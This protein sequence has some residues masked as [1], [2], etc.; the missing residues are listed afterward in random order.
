MTRRVGAAVTPGPVGLAL[1]AGVITYLAVLVIVPLATLAHK[2]LAGGAGAVWKAASSPVAADALVLTLWTAAVMAVVNAVM[3]TATAWVLVRFRFPG[4]RLLSALVDLPFA[5]PTLVAGIMLV[6]LFGPQTPL[7]AW[8][9]AHGIKIVFADPGIILALLFI[10]MPLVVRAVEPV[11]MEIDPAE[12][13]AAATLGA[14]PL[15]TFRRVVLPPVIPAIASGTIQCFARALAEF[16]SVVV[17]SG[18]IPNRTLTAPVYI[19]G[20][21]ESDRPGTAAAVSLLLLAVAV[22]ALFATRG[23]QQFVGRDRA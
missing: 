17:V 7:G 20:E 14:S 9:A 3:G 13:E 10:T 5:I 22:A 8:M 23:L 11:L 6:T 16:G 21:V 4:R 1:R 2:G 15:V 18:N 12:E 19:F